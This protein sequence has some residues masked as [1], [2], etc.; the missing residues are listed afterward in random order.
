MFII[1]CSSVS[2]GQSAYHQLYSPRHSR[3]SLVVASLSY[4]VGCTMI[5]SS[6]CPRIVSEPWLSELSCQTSML[7]SAYA[8]QYGQRLLR[9][10][11]VPVAGT[12][13]TG[14]CHA[15][16]PPEPYPIGYRIPLA[17]SS[18]VQIEKPPAYKA[19]GCVFIY[20]DKL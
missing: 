15:G 12:S 14:G 7:L 6:F 19:S 9:L 8:V 17:L 5:A 13:R 20:I 4:G 2:W 18:F 10:L 3:S 1:V 11:S 16:K